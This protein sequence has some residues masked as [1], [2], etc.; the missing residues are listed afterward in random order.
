MLECGMRKIL[1]A[2]YLIVFILNTACQSVGP[3]G[4]NGS[5]SGQ[6]GS[7]NIEWDHQL[8]TAIHAQES[9]E[10]AVVEHFKIVN[11]GPGTPS[12]HNLWVALIQDLPPYQEVEQTSISTG[13]YRIFSD[14]YSNSIAEFDLG[15]LSPG[16]AISL[17]IAY[18]LKVHKLEYDLSKCTG[19]MPSIFLSPE[20]FIESDNPQIRSLSAELAQGHSNPCEWARSIF[21]Y[22]GDNL[23]YTY[24]GKDW[25]AQAALGEMGSDC[26]E[27]SDLMV[28]LSRAAGIPAVYLEGLVYL[29][30][31]S[32]ALARREHAW[33]EVYLPGIGWAPMD[34]TMGR[35][36][37]QRESFFAANSPDHIIVTRGRNPSAL[38]GGS[39]F[40]HIYWPGPSADIKIEE[41]SWQI[42]PIE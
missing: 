7:H 4:V 22:I 19:S 2:S 20:L 31:G 28:A 42:T 5:G 15:D 32:E 35:S 33:L 12:R 29:E 11:H 26:S 36:L 25:G 14:E 27:Y 23:I 8:S 30:P 3:S 9:V 38:R 24:N 18:R 16:Q 10:Y 6:A 40:S 21:N 37:S 17:D 1:Y 39:Y 41:F 34:P 13:E